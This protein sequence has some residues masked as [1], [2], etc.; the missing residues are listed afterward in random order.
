[1]LTLMNDPQTTD[2]KNLKKSHTDK[3]LGG[4]CGGLAN[5]TALPSWLWRVILYTLGLECRHRHPSL[6]SNVDFH[7]QTNE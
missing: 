2:L 1:M 6:H 7:A 5:A 4:V 3:M